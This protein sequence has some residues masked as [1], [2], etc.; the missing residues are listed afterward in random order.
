LVALVIC[1]RKL[2]AFQ[3]ATTQ[4]TKFKTALHAV[5]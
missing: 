4:F 3:T 1:Y 2:S 5:T